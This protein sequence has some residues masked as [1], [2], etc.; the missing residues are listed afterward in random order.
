MAVH[1]GLLQRR[2]V[3]AQCEKDA[4][5]FEAIYDIWLMDIKIYDKLG[6]PV[7]GR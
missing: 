3:M 1:P 4:H 6:I 5:G 2:G 7:K